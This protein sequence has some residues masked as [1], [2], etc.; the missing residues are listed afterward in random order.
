MQ[1]AVAVPLDGDSR[2]HN[3]SQDSGR[4]DSSVPPPTP[5]RNYIE[6]GIPMISDKIDDFEDEIQVIEIHKDNS[7]FGFSI[8]GGAEYQSPLF[9]LKIA[10]NGAAERNGR[11]RV[12]DEI[13]E[14][15]DTI[16]EGMMH[17][18]A[19]E[20]IKSGGRSVKLII[21]RAPED[22]MQEGQQPTF[23]PQQVNVNMNNSGSRTTPDPRS[24]SSSS[25]ANMK[26]YQDYMESL[27]QK[28]R[29]GDRFEN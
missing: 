13:L 18:N 14:I 12:G 23:V 26:Y 10:P 11:L 19:I 25:A 4:L 5:P 22:V 9:V 6:D 1:T 8:Q 7:G 27:R 3:Y 28:G 2:M 21:R 16:T 17:T 29:D 24:P 15:N 20:V